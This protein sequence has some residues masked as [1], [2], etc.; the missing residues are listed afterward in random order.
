MAKNKPAA[1]YQT[2][3]DEL[4]TIIAELQREDIDVD[5]ALKHYER[6]LE[7]VKQLQAYLKTAENK[8]VELKAKF[9]TE[10]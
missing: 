10:T 6:G 9:T 5:E 3:N 7:L 8:V 2:L 1:N 4:E